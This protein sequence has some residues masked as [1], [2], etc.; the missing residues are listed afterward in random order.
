MRVCVCAFTTCLLLGVSIKRSQQ[1]NTNTKLFE[2]RT[3]PKFTS[4]WQQLLWCHVVRLGLLCPFPTILY[5][6]YSPSRTRSR[7][8]KRD[9]FLTNKTPS[10]P[11][12]NYSIAEQG[13]KKLYIQPNLELVHLHRQR[14]QRPAAFIL[15]QCLS[16]V[17]RSTC[18]DFAKAGSRHYSS[19]PSNS[20]IRRHYFFII[21]VPISIDIDGAFA[22][23]I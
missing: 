1:R 20:H 5:V 2:L 14:F 15:C 3:C 22:T 9:D 6:P 8:W 4:K 7:R 23:A 19:H 17:C 12:A 18:V 10:H 13:K 16:L 21:D 11:H